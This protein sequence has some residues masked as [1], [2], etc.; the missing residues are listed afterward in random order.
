METKHT[1]GEWQIGA[2]FE[3]YSKSGSITIEAKGNN[4][5]EWIAEAK[6]SHVNPGMG[7][8]EW[9]ANAKLIAAAPDLLEAL[10]RFVDFVDKQNLDYESSM[11]LQAKAAIKKATE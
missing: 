6:G 4:S 8:D 5:R 2:M 9:E 7:K 11:L 3:Y 1:K 10:Q